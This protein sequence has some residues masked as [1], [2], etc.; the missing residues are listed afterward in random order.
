M[1]NGGGIPHFAHV[2]D[3]VS[4][5]NIAIALKIC[6]LMKRL[7]ISEINQA[8]AALFQSQFCSTCIRNL[9]PLTPARMISRLPMLSRPITLSHGRP[10]RVIYSNQRTKKIRLRVSGLNFA[11]RHPVKR[12]PWLWCYQ[13][14]ILW[15]KSLRTVLPDALSLNCRMATLHPKLG[16]VLRCKQLNPRGGA[17]EST[18]HNP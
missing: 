18:T 8:K 14:N 10:G 4:W 17:A 6:T 11:S 3:G 16:Y 15:M 7:V 13:H 2:K 1:G 9:D 12:G 5:R